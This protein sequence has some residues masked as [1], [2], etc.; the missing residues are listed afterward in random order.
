MTTFRPL[1]DCAQTTFMRFAWKTEK[2]NPKNFRR[3]KCIIGLELWITRKTIIN[4]QLKCDREHGKGSVWALWELLGHVLCLLFR[5]F[6]LVIYR[7]HLCIGLARCVLVAGHPSA[8]ISTCLLT[9]AREFFR[10]GGRFWAAIDCVTCECGRSISPKR[11]FFRDK[12][13]GCWYLAACA[14]PFDINSAYRPS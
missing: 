12:L 2:K 14:R 11:T 1:P 13:C 5:P 3:S 7:D 9:S 10:R 8:P 4:L 6:P